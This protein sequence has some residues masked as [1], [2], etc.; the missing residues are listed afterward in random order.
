MPGQRRGTDDR[1]RRD[2]QRVRGRATA[3]ASRFRAATS[4]AS[5]AIP[6]PARLRPRA[7]S[8]AAPSR[9]CSMTRGV[10]R[11]SCCPSCPAEMIRGPFLAA[12]FLG[13]M[14]LPRGGEAGQRGAG[15]TPPPESG[16]ALDLP[17]AFDG[18]PPPVAPATI[19]RDG[20]DGPRFAPCVSRR[21]SGS[22]ASSTR[23]STRACRRSRTSSRPSR[24]RAQPATREDR[25][26]GDRSTT[27]TSTSRSAA[28]RASRSGWS[29]TRCGA[30]TRRLYQQRQLR[31]RLR[32][33]LRPAQRRLLRRQRRSAAAS[34]AR[35]PTSGSSTATGT[36]SGTSRSAASTAAGR[37]KPRS[38]SSRCA[39]GP[40]RA[41]IWGFN[42]QRVNR[43]KNEISYAD[44]DAGGAADRAASCSSRSRRRWSA[45]KRRRARRT[46]TSSRTSS[47]T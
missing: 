26:L 42:V 38:R 34:T 37:S 4:R 21:R 6:T 5:I 17:F 43:W 1:R 14:M 18:P 7:P 25:G 33:V 13:A 39:T 10:H 24:T 20:P 35:S 36:R 41:Q 45:S 40:G 16:P 32:H 31:L 22:T 3:S 2:E 29:P 28:G 8:F 23:R 44:A 9:R 19:A 11:G 30:T 12:L 27:T 47:R 46:S 15:P